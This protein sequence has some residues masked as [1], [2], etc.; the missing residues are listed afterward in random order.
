MLCK[1]LKELQQFATIARRSLDTFT[2]DQGPDYR[3]R[4]TLAGVKAEVKKYHLVVLASADEADE[5]EYPRLLLALRMLKQCCK[6][7][8]KTVRL[9]AVV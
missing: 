8:I 1:F 4:L 7:W 9:C 2:S 6:P 3:L 5:Y